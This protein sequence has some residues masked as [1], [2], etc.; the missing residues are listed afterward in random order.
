MR[1]RID[2]SDL[3]R[4]QRLEVLRKGV[5]EPVRH[6]LH[7]DDGCAEVRGER[8]QDGRHRLR[9]AGPGSDRDDRK[10]RSVRQRRHPLGLGRRLA[11]LGV[12]EHRRARQRPNLGAQADHAPLVGD[13]RL[14][15]EV[16][17]A[18]LDRTE[19]EIRLRSETLA[20]HDEDRDRARVHDALDGLEAVRSRHVDVHRD[21]V[22]LVLLDARD[23]LEAVRG[24][25]DD[26]DVAIGLEDLL[27][28]HP[29]ERRVVDCD[30]ADHQ[31]PVSPAVAWPPAWTASIAV[32]RSA[33]SFDSRGRSP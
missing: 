3:E 32:C 6:L 18:E 10:R 33:M 30:D 23:G 21:D 1:H 2:G 11:V 19:A 31:P 22:R 15:H 9:A 8:R 20:G 13:R 12:E 27:Q 16:E 7:D 4:S 29:R 5:A 14:R 25:S 26:L 24:R 28:D 17:R